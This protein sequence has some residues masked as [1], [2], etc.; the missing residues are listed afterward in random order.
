MITYVVSDLLKSPADVLVN[1][2]NTVGVMGKGI[3]NDFKKVYPE[4]FVRYQKLCERGQFNIGQLWIFK[5][6][7]KW[8][9]NFPTK[10]HWRNPSKIEYIENG[11]EKFVKTYAEKGITSISFPMLGCGNGELNWETEVRPLMEKYLRNIPIDIYSS[12]P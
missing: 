6:K 12:L 9:L 1:T 10:K 7:N 11:L 5:K 2:V 4:M 3:A 8:V